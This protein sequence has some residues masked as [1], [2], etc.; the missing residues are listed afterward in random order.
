MIVP[1]RFPLP[2]VIAE[3]EMRMK[4]TSSDTT[5]SPWGLSSFP[6]IHTTNQQSTTSLSLEPT[7]LARTLSSD[8]SL[9]LVYGPSHTF[10]CSQS[11]VHDSVASPHP[12]ALSQPESALTD[13]RGVEE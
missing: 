4:I 6:H 1:D 12:T 2:V 5:V 9:P 7:C 3:A 8:M 11:I 10:V 13:V